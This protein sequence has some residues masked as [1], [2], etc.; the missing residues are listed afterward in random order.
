M[1]VVYCTPYKP[2]CW[3]TVVCYLQGMPDRMLCAVLEQFQLYFS[4]WY[5][6]FVS[7]QSVISSCVLMLKR[8]VQF[9]FFCIHTFMKRNT[10]TQPLKCTGNHAFTPAHGAQHI[11]AASWCRVRWRSC[12]IFRDGKLLELFQVHLFCVPCVLRCVSRW[13]FN[14]ATRL[15]WK[16]H[17]SALAIQ[18]REV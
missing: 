1:W 8:P 2:W 13:P 4:L 15:I 6:R 18:V 12:M 11:L 17:S 3:L 14:S 10:Y 9:S 7:I 16:L 5:V